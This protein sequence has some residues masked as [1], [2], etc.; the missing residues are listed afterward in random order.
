MK[1]AYIFYIA[2]T[3]SGQVML[4]WPIFWSVFIAVSFS[5]VLGAVYKLLTFIVGPE[6]Y[7]MWRWP[8]PD[9]DVR[10]K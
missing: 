8:R 6:F 3:S 2:T 1:T 4:K 7:E 5:S 10:A 9:Q